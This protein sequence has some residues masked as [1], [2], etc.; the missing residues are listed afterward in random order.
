M[1]IA[2]HE[3][4][5]SISMFC[6]AGNRTVSHILLPWGGSRPI[7]SKRSQDTHTAFF[8]SFLHS[9]QD[10]FRTS[11]VRG[12][13]SI[14]NLLGF[15]LGSKTRI[16]IDSRSIQDP[17]KSKIKRQN[18]CFYFFPFSPSKM[19]QH[20]RAGKTKSRTPFYLFCP[21]IHGNLGVP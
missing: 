11:N 6:N 15:A 18:K 4:F 3:C 9:G 21:P 7:G 8:T 5:V 10:E 14:S 17:F 16:A 20:L 2:S 12:R 19:P 1:L 13:S